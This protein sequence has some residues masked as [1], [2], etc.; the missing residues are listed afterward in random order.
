M[1]MQQGG[2]QVDENGIVQGADQNAVNQFFNGYNQ[3]A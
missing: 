3:V 1:A 2:G